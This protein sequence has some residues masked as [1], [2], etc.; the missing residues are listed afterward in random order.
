MSTLAVIET[1]P[2]LFEVGDVKQ[3]G[4]ASVPYKIIVQQVA[5]ATAPSLAGT[6]NGVSATLVE[7][8]VYRVTSPG[9]VTLTCSVAA[10]KVIVQ[11]L[12]VAEQW[13]FS[14]PV[15]EDYIQTECPVLIEGP[16]SGAGT[17]V[18]ANTM[19]YR[20]ISFDKAHKFNK[21]AICKASTLNAAT[22]VIGAVFDLDGNVIAN[23]ALAGTAV[24]ASG[25]VYTAGIALSKT[26]QDFERGR[27]YLLGFAAND[28]N[29]N[30][31]TSSWFGVGGSVAA[32][33]DFTSALTDP[34]TPVTSYI[35]APTFKMLAYYS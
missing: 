16:S 19:Y 2:I 30:Y 33:V 29:T 24:G 21:V 15:P 18:T 7:G 26:V 6:V 11:P 8:T 27:E 25:N 17:A 9:K 5:S 12:S 14:R 20:K 10:A 32:A 13:L 35:S 23:T 34:I 1:K 22:K 4:Y 31:E 3:I 28:T